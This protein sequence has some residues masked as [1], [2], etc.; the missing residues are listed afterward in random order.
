MTFREWISLKTPQTL[1][2]VCGYRDGTIRMWAS[3]NVIPRGVWPDL[4]ETGLASLK[5]LMAMET[6]SRQP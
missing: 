4:Q 5:E 1:H 6:A 3:R 2:D